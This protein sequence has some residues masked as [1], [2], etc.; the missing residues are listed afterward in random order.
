MI[1]IRYNIEDLDTTTEIYRNLCEVLKDEQVIALL[2]D[3]D[4]LFNCSTSDL[5]YYKEMIEN[6][7]HDKEI[8]EE[9]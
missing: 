9:Y 1:V 8:A 5:Y 4:I 7:I 2:Q 3:W 6:A